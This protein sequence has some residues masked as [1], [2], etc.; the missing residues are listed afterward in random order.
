MP[1]REHSAIL[2]TF[3]KLTFEIKIFILSIFKLA[4]LDRFYC[5]SV[6]DEP[7]CVSMAIQ[8]YTNQGGGGGRGSDLPIV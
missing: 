5:I 4:A 3:I 1:Q 7:R 6:W 2:S 8:I